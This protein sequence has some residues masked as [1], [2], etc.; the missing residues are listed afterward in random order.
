MKTKTP[1]TTTRAANRTAATAVERLARRTPGWP[2]ALQPGR[3]NYNL[4]PV[5]DSECPF[6]VHIS[7]FENRSALPSC[8]QRLNA[9]PPL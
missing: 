9:A 1:T 7:R 4:G 6:Y 2:Y 8:T 3:P 5:A